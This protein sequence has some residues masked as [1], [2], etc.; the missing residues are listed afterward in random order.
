MIM[1]CY[2]IGVTRTVAAVI[3]QHH[4]EKGNCLARKAL[5]PS[6]STFSLWEPICRRL[7]KLATG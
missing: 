4:D 7:S 1:G 3:E 2:G 6:M 5:R